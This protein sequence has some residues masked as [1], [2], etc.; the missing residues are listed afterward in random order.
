MPNPALNTR[1][2]RRADCEKCVT[3]FFV[4]GGCDKA[5]SGA[6]EQVQAALPRGCGHCIEARPAQNPVAPRSTQR[7]LL[8][9]ARANHGSLATAAVTPVRALSLKSSQ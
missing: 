9:T 7:A 3:G 6:A 8:M 2:P 1:C 5:L 4:H